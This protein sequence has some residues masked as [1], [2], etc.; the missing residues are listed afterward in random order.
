MIQTPT[1]S[2]TFSRNTMTGDNFYKFRVVEAETRHVQIDLLDISTLYRHVVSYF[3][4][5]NRT[6]YLRDTAIFAKSRLYLYANVSVKLSNVLYRIRDD[7]RREP[8]KISN[9]SKFYGLYRVSQSSRR[10]R[11]GRRI[12]HDRWNKNQRYARVFL[13]PR[14]FF[15]PFFFPFF[16]PIP[17]CREHITPD[18]LLDFLA[19]LK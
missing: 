12:V 7:G 14:F 2:E 1:A 6:E 16:S 19:T 4:R 13:L 9:E 18:T 3:I 11:K 10:G 17:T 15:L 5:C 8:Y